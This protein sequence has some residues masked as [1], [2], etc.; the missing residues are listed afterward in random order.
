MIGAVVIKAEYI[1]EAKEKY[2]QEKVDV[3]F[4]LLNGNHP[5]IILNEL[6]GDE[7]EC[8]L[9]LMRNRYQKDETKK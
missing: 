4:K 1:A 3:I 7:K 5:D 6:E 9:I 2:G 8:F